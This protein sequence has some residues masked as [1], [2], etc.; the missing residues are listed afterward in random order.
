MYVSLEDYVPIKLSTHQ[1]GAESHTRTRK[2][3]N[4]LEH[5]TEHSSENPPEKVTTL[6]KMPLNY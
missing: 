2:H 3:E 4:P 5:N 1:A 6:W